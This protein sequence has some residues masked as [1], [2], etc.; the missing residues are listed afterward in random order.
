MAESTGS[1]WSAR[2]TALSPGS[3]DPLPHQAA[4]VS[5]AACHIT[6]TNPPHDASDIKSRTQR[7]MT[8]SPLRVP[9]MFYVL[10]AFL[11]RSG[12]G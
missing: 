8:A 2:G 1:T 5:S 10:V 6:Q 7:A 3:G 11:S 9:V 4:V 12:E